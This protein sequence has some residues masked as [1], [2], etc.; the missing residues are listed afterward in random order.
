MFES[1]MNLLADVIIQMAAIGGLS[2]MASAGAKNDNGDA[3][4]PL[5]TLN[6]FQTRGN[7]ARFLSG[8]IYVSICPVV[9]TEN[10]LEW[11]QYI[12]SDV[13]SWM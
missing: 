11:E 13:N 4:W 10:I 6:A 3:A 1:L 2:A 8:A 7:N 12:V 9:R 5:V